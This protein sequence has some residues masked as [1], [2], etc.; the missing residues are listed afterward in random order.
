MNDFS[1][2]LGYYRQDTDDLTELSV[3]DKTHGFPD[4]ALKSPASGARG[5]P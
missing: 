3:L 4:G 5:A 1:R 2:L